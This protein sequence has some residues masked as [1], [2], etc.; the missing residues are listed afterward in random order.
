V[1]EG[2][3]EV[4]EVGMLQALYTPSAPWLFIPSWFCV[5]LGLFVQL[6]CLKKKKAKWFLVILAFSLI[7]S[8][9]ACQLITGWDVLIF[10]ILYGFFIYML[11]GAAL[12]TIIH[13]LQKL[14][15]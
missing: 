1:L 13:C 11:L 3:K 10:L 2:L 9:L 4:I 15:K 12:G 7:F 14:K 8:E 6:R 5:I